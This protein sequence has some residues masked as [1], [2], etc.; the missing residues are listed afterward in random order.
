MITDD[1]DI[2]PQVTQAEALRD[3]RAMLPPGSTVHTIARHVSQSGMSRII[4]PV[5]G[6]ISRGAGITPTTM[7]AVMAGCAVIGVLALWLIVRPRTV[8]MLT[9]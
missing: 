4:S 5:V 7:A 9:P 1:I 6:W 2:T 3:L 8:A